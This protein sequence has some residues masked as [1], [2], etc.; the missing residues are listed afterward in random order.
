MKYNFIFDD[1][2]TS[3]G[4]LEKVESVDIDVNRKTIKEM[5][6]GLNYYVMW[7]GSG[8]NIDKSK[9]ELINQGKM[10]LLLISDGEA[11]QEMTLDWAMDVIKDF[12]INST[13]VIFMSYDLR[14]DETYKLLLKEFSKFRKYPLS[15]I[16]M[17]TY[18]FESHKT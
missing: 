13:Q 15:V 12:K 2:N 17:D 6:D 9:V 5:G 18:C 7:S 8:N 16:G 1:D 3:M 11:L 4:F 10:K 14:S